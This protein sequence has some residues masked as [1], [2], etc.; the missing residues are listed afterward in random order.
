MVS[1]WDR[2]TPALSAVLRNHAC[3]IKPIRDQG[4]VGRTRRR[5][6]CGSLPAN[7]RAVVKARAVWRRVID[8]LCWR[9]P[10]PEPALENFQIRETSSLV[11]FCPPGSGRFFGSRT[12]EDDLPIT[13]PGPRLQIAERKNSA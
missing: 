5:L 6:L 11:L 10:S 8:P 13:R 1:P 3:E 4:I 7:T 2:R 9:L 12:V